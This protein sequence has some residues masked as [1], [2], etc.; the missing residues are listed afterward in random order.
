MSFCQGFGSWQ[1]D[2]SCVCVRSCTGSTRFQQLEEL[3]VA[4][5]DGRGGK[6]FEQEQRAG[7]AASPLLALEHFVLQCS[8]LICGP[9]GLEQPSLDAPIAL[10]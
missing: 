9:A 7:A 4:L 1:L 6:E 10:P 5:R 2:F 3:G 8:D